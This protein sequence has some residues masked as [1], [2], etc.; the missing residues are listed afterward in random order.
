MI[1]SRFA[2][3]ASRLGVAALLAAQAGLAAPAL[4]QY[5]PTRGYSATVLNFDPTPGT[6]T[7]AAMTWG[8]GV[9]NRGE[10]VGQY[11]LD[12]PEGFLWSAAGGMTLLEDLFQ[13]HEPVRGTRIGDDGRIVGNF[14]EMDLRP[15]PGF[16]EVIVFAFAGDTSG[17]FEPLSPHLM[18]T[19]SA[20]TDFDSAGRVVGMLNADSFGGPRAVIWDGAEVIN[21]GTLGANNSTATG[22][23]ES[24]VVIGQS[25]FI[26]FGPVR[27]FR[28][29]ETTGMEA[30]PLPPDMTVSDANDIND[31]GFIVGRVSNLGVAFASR[32][33]PDGSVEI[34]PSPDPS[35]FF[36]Q[37]RRI[38]E[39][40]QVLGNA[41]VDFDLAVVL[42]HEGEPVVVA[43]HVVDLPEEIT[44]QEAADLTDDGHILCNGFD[45]DAIAF[46]TVLLTPLDSV[47]RA[48]LD[49]DGE[50][51]FFDFL[52]FQDLFAAGDLRADF[53]GDGDLTFF[54]FLAF[55]NE[56]A[57][58]CP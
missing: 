25:Q 10:V 51:T 14:G 6:P 17:G 37:A 42:W 2:L 45:S 3:S 32:W 9:N 12:F 18:Q 44:L 40:G 43:D 5:D 24:G 55:Q 57:A 39:H 28:W 54:D 34:L 53:D 8:A 13:W 21:L 26:E 23:N 4:A 56:F 47:C 52:M 30:L 22:I 31:D 36:A 48:D 16:P 19:S 29:T 20:A 58:G 7:Q 38:N 35:G 11:G 1:R 46:V 41:M 50:L 15:S 27:G 49:G 33:A